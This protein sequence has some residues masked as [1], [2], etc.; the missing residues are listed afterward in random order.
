MYAWRCMKTSSTAVKHQ[1]SEYAYTQLSL[2][3][4]YRLS[5]ICLSTQVVTLTLCR[6]WAKN[7]WKH[8]LTETTA[9]ALTWQHPPREARP[10]P[11]NQ[12]QQHAV[13]MAIVKQSNCTSQTISTSRLLY[14]A[15]HVIPRSFFCWVT[16]LQIVIQP[17]TASCQGTR[18][19]SDSVSSQGSAAERPHAYSAI[20]SL[21]LAINQVS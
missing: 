10:K 20:K 9:V 3:N 14:A 18:P 21:F 17:L 7:G 13:G 4:V 8:E 2:H 16:A 12:P 11:V 1:N 5:L 19:S 15:C 6:A